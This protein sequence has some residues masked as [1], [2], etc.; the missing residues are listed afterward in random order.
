MLKN[1]NII[2]CH[3]I[4]KLLP[5]LCKKYYGSFIGAA[6][7]AILAVLF[8]CLSEFH[9]IPFISLS[10]ETTVLLESIV[11]PL[12]L[13]IMFLAVIVSGPLVILFWLFL[14][15]GTYIISIFH[16]ILT[17]IIYGA[18]GLGIHYSLLRS[19]TLFNNKVDKN[20]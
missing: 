18:I 15:I 3:K 7:G 9:K 14:P 5:S 17:I 19:V 4:M 10:P 1:L 13:P 16:I 11:F 8:Y 6:I 12:V 20:S 2:I